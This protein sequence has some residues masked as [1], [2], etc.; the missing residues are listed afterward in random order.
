MSHKVYLI[1]WSIDYTLKNFSLNE[2]NIFIDDI[3]WFIT[4]FCL[5][6]KGNTNTLMLIWIGRWLT[7]THW[8]FWVSVPSIIKIYIKYL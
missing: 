2:V 1:W 8:E 5:L 4:T 3:G 7:I 6:N